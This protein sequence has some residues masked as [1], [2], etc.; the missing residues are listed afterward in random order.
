MNG[1]EPAEHPVESTT[2]IE[3]LRCSECQQPVSPESKFCSSCGAAVNEVGTGTLPPVGDTGPTP[4]INDEL[5]QD[6]EPG[7][8]VLLVH[9]GPE[10]G[11][12]FPLVESSVSIGR[13]RQA[14]IFLDDVTVSRKHAQLDRGSDSWRISD[15][16]SLNG[17]YLNRERVEDSVLASG[18]EIQVGKYRFIFLEVP[19]Q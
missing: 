2:N 3:L 17:T 10:E 19:V 13:A 9:R 18:D 8:A 15:V 5:F 6:L 4:A 14:T 16:G 1:E 12:R 7:S 11:Q